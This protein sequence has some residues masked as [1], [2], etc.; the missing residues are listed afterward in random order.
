MKNDF[1]GETELREWLKSCPKYGN[2]EEAPDQEAARLADEVSD[3][4]NGLRNDLGNGYRVDFS[5]PSTHLLYGYWV[6][7]LPDGRKARDM[8][9]YGVD[10]FYGDASNGLGLRTLSTMKLPYEKF[11]GGYASHIGIDPKYFSGSDFAQR[12][13]QFRDRVLK[14]LFFNVLQSG[15]SPFYLYVNITTAQTLRAVLADP[16]RYAPNGVYIMRIHGTFVNFLDL[17]PAIQEDII[18]RLDPASTAIA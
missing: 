2:N 9:N 18:C 15:L 17:S 5:T 4:V 10:P 14:P 7:A 12:G 16:K 3:L 6:G 11:V 1:A 8:L 13:I